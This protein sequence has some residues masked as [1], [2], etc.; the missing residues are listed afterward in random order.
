M[1]DL[2]LVPGF[3][4]TAGAWDDVRAALPT[5]A[6]ARPL[7]VPAGATFEATAARLA[8][9]GRGVWSGYSMGGRL[10]LSIALDRPAAVEALV[11][12]STNP[13]LEDARERAT[14]RR[15]DEDLATLVESDGRERFLEQWV[16]QP[17]FDGLDPTEALRHRLSSPTELARQ[18]RILGQGTHQPMWDRLGE[19]TMP[20]AV[21]AG[22]RDEKY[23]AIARRIVSA[24]GT[25]AS[26][27]IVPGAGHALLQEAPATVAEIL[28]TL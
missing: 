28:S 26:L 25:N 17:I 24:V 15:S 12:V 16:A 4:Q 10:A 7:D 19:L 13:G 22:E 2:Y 21:M 27:H 1:T 5:T 3:S 14:R 8:R 11:L 23:T 18:L 20:V 6:R 9:E